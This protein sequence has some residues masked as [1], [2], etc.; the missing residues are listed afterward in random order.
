MWALGWHQSKW[1]YKSTEDL[2]NVINQYEAKN[3]PLDTIWSDIDYME[4]YKDFTFDPVNYGDLPQFVEE[5]HENNLQYIPIIDAGIAQR[6]G[7]N[8]SVYDTGV[9]QDVFVKAYEEGPTFTGEVWPVDAVYPNFF[10]NA[11]NVWWQKNLD[12]FSKVVDFDGLWL[13]MN[14]ATNYCNGVCYKS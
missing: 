9:E 11:T 1:G 7:Q 3:L 4:D 12:D 10:K 2:R 6:K 5:I 13:D 8:Y 14:E